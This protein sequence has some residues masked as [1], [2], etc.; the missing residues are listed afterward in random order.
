VFRLP[1]TAGLSLGSS[2]VS[3]ASLEVVVRRQ[4]LERQSAGW[5]GSFWTFEGWG[6]QECVGVTIAVSNQYVLFIP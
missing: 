5:F 6:S 2:K 4:G 3:L 1:L